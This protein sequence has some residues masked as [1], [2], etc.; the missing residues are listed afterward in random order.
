VRIPSLEELH[1]PFAAA[2]GA[3]TGMEASICL[4]GLAT[5]QQPMGSADA[6]AGRASEKT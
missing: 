3:N 4:A 2:H 1:R 6:M 5:D